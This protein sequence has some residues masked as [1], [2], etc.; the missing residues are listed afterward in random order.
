MKVK[1]KDDGT[2]E[3]KRKPRITND[4]YSKSIID[5]LNA[6]D[7]LFE[8]AKQTSEFEFILTLLR[9]RGLQAAGWDPFETTQEALSCISRLQGKIRDFKTSRHLFLWLYGHIIE[10]S[11]P[12][13]ILVNLINI[14]SGNRFRID[15]FPD[16]PKGKYLIPQSPSE[17]IQELEEMASTIGMGSAVVPLKNAFDRDLRNA[18]FHADYAL[19]DGEVRIKKPLKSYTNEEITTILSKGLAYYQAFV[20]MFNSYIRSYDKPKI[21]PVHP[22]FA[23]RPNH[24]AI[25]IVREEYGLVGIRDY[26]EKQEDRVG[27][28]PFMVGRFLDYE[29]KL[30]DRDPTL[31]ILPKNKIERI[32]RIL[33]FF[34]KFIS[35]RIVKLYRTK[36]LP[37]T[38]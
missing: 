37:M 25:T 1:R 9:I 5:Y 6:F 3:Y 34:P 36:N 7:P 32:N 17:K 2:W 27:Q 26:F 10:A 24:N 23:T 14:C 22:E 18:V 20:S 28:F 33:M 11:E 12:Y 16:K 30:L 15:N 38:S 4:V 19:Y 21:L 29:S 13:E 35:S 8:R 31:C